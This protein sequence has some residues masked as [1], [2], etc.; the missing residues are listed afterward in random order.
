VASSLP[1]D[2]DI[3]TTTSADIVT[4]TNDGMTLIYSDSPLGAIGSVGIS[5]VCE[6]AWRPYAAVG[7]KVL[8]AV[9][10]SKSKATPSGGLAIVD[11]AS[12][13]PAISQGR[14]FH[15]AEQG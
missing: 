6:R 8:V 12:K 2:K 4:A 1:V 9:D 13:A 5:E 11:V 3:P 14:G 10:T 15:R 7:G